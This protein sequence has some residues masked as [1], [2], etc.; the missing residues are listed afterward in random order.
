MHASFS[1]SNLMRP[2]SKGRTALDLVDSAL[3]YIVGDLEY[4][5]SEESTVL[6]AEVCIAQ[7]CLTSSANFL[8]QSMFLYL[9]M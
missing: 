5:G 7:C 2:R 9:S 1:L 3:L 6:F 4:R 8:F